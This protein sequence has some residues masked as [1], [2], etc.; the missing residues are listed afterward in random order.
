VLLYFLEKTLTIIEIRHNQYVR[1]PRPFSPSRL[2]Y[3]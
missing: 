1:A 3:L 2:Y